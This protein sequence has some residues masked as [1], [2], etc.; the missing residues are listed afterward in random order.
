MAT[1]SVALSERKG[2]ITEIS[3]TSHVSPGAIFS[4]SLTV[5]VSVDTSTSISLGLWQIS[6]YVDAWVDSVKEKVRGDFEKKYT[7][8]ATAPTEATYVSYYVKLSYWDEGADKWHMMDEERFFLTTYVPWKRLEGDHIVILFQV[9]TPE[10][11]QVDHALGLLPYLDQAYELFRD[12]TGNAPYHGLKIGIVY[13]SSIVDEFGQSVVGLG[14]NPIQMRDYPTAN[15]T[16]ELQ[17]YFHELSHDFTMYDLR[18]AGLR[19]TKSVDEG[20]AELGRLYIDYRLG[21]EFAQ[22]L[23]I[24]DRGLSIPRFIDRLR[25][26]EEARSPFSEVRWNASH[27]REEG[28]YPSDYLLGAILLAIVEVRGWDFVS[29]LFSDVTD[30]VDLHPVFGDELDLGAQMNSLVYLLSL[31]TEYD[32]TSVFEYWH[33]PLQIDSDDD[34]L[35]DGKEIG[36]GLSKSDFDEDGLMDDEE[37]ILGT[38]PYASDSDDDRLDD[39]EEVNKYGTN[40]LK[41]DTDN[42]GLPDGREIQLGTNPLKADTDGDGLPDGKEIQLG[43]DL[44][45]AD[46]DGDELSDGDE[47]VKHRT[48]PLKL[49]TDADGLGD[50]EEIKRGT[51]PL[52]ADTDD[53]YWNDSIDVRPRDALIPNVV[54]VI[55][56]VLVVLLVL[57]KRR[58]PRPPPAQPVAAAPV[59][60]AEKFCIN[61]GSRIPGTAAFCGKCEAQQT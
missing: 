7:L 44:L 48:D 37:L 4:V 25:D 12:W 45:K 18:R 42:D 43:T 49:D 21:G 1:V 22:Y 8:S 23:S 53:D 56:M 50:G 35:T 46:T 10:M 26:Y 61:C 15:A 9:E 13:N 6:P 5:H 54:V 51:D 58:K 59:G 32:L 28:Q 33:F 3:Y 38:R 57:M 27:P 20:F 36:Q 60:A 17:S 29:R 14:G 30:R 24:G 31:A 41:P 34:G 2:T 16:S 19:D 55:A 39:G 52:K 40:P 47:V 11:E